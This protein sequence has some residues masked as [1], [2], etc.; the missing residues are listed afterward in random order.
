MPALARQLMTADEFL[1]WALEQEDKY[2]LVDGVPVKKYGNDTPEMMANG[3][4]NHAQVISNIHRHLG[5]RLAGGSCQTYTDVFSVRTSITKQRR[6]DVIVDCGRGGPDDLE[7]TAPTVLFEVLSPN[8][9]DEDLIVK[10]EEYKRI[11]T[12]QQYVV[13]DPD[14]VRIKVWI[15]D[16]DGRWSD[17]A[18]TPPAETLPLPALGVELPLDEVYEGIELA[19]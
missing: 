17:H 15:R 7:A 10:P 18:I 4:R 9:R 13:V 19:A 8:S 6:P 11:T 1:L 12:L 14:R 5:N 3:R 2:E 16:A